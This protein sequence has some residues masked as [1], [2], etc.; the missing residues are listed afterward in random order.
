MPYNFHSN[1][2]TSPAPTPDAATLSSS[3][4]PRESTAILARGNSTTHLLVILQFG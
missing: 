3:P 4:G 2:I 1:L